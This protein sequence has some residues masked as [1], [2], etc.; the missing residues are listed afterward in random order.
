ME[1]KLF[2]YG[3]IFTA[4]RA[5]SEH[6]SL[7]FVPAI[8]YTRAN[9]GNHLDSNPAGDLTL[10]TQFWSP[11]FQL[12]YIHRMGE[13]VKSLLALMAGLHSVKTFRPDRAV[14]EVVPTA[15]LRFQF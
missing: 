1:T 11:G 6:G 15:D 7:L 8:Y 3:L 13:E 9:S 10:R 14:R 12:G 5:L 2:D 4:E